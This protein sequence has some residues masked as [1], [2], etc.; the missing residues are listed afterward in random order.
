MK[1]ELTTVT[2]A[3]LLQYFP[4]DPYSDLEIRSTSMEYKLQIAF[5]SIE[6]E[7]FEEVYNLKQKQVVLTHLP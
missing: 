7:Y 6:S 4:V 2:N 1:I 3:K 5:L